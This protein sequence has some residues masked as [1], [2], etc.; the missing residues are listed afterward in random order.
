M[1][2]S[3]DELAQ[4]APWLVRFKHARTDRAV[5]K[6]L[7][8]APKKVSKLLLKILV[9]VLLGRVPTPPR[10]RQLAEKQSLRQ[11]LVDELGGRERAT[12]AARSVAATRDV[13][14]KFAALLP[15]AVGAF[16]KCQYRL[17]IPPRS[18]KSEK[19]Q[20]GRVCGGGGGGG[21]EK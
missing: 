6:L 21:R 11:A 19:E 12:A 20:R 1:N 13:C 4:H 9:A 10:F 15:V 16:L 18:P 14:A 5:K 2:I 7:E 17:K 8:E 3:P